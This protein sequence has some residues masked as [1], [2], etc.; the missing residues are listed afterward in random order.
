[1]LRSFVLPLAIVLAVSSVAWSEEGKKPKLRIDQREHNFGTVMQGDVVQH[2]FALH[3]DGEAELIIERIVPGCGCTA[4]KLD[5]DVIKPGASGRLQIS[6]DTKGFSGQKER[7]ISVYTNDFVEPSVRLLLKGK[8]D[9]SIVVTPPRVAF[10]NVV[11]GV[12]DPRNSQ[13]VLVK[14]KSSEQN[15]E[16]TDLISTSEHLEVDELES[17]PR[18]K[19]LRV[20]VVGD[21]PEGALREQILIGLKGGSRPNINIPV[22]ASVKGLLRLQPR[23]L[24]FGILEGEQPVSRA[25]R[26]KSLAPGDVKIK[27]IKVDNPAVSVESMTAK[28]GSAYVI[29][30]LVNPSQLEEDLRET[31]EIVTDLPDEPPIALNV[32]GVLP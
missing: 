3:N 30:V 9:T 32:Y 4:T 15:L 31:I 24:S 26:L 11:R 29:K 17:S 27:E 7:I 14:I 6:F 23:S 2:N 28:A 13:E 16:L 12:A 5:A 10:N 20:S 25:A 8:I 22:Y 19:R 18:R 21:A 1:M